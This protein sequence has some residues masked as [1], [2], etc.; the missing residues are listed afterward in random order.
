VLRFTQVTGAGSSVLTTSEQ[1]PIPPLRFQPGDPCRSIDISTTAI[2]TGPVEVTI[3]Y[4]GTT[5][6]DESRLRM[7]HQEG[8]AWVDRTT[9][10]DTAAKK[11]IGTVFSLSPFGIFEPANQPPV[12]ACRNVVNVADDTCRATATAGEINDGS[13]DPDGDPITLAISPSGPFPLGTTPVMLTV[14]D[15]AGETSTCAATVTVVDQSA[16]AV[17]ASFAAI[18]AQKKEG[19]FRVEYTSAD[20]CDASPVNTAVME[21][22]AG[23]GGY[24]VVFERADER[25]ISFR[26]RDRRIQLQGPDEASMRQLLQTILADG[27]AA[28]TPGQELRLHLDESQTMRSEFRFSGNELMEVLSPHLRLRVTARDSSGNSNAATAVPPFASK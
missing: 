5:Y 27:G 11:I 25:K 16:P 9:S 17:T 7:F 24:G 13:S 22:P 14:S 3:D 18:K 23:A 15:A 20:H 2:F 28:V 10:L 21:I 1:C 19:R 4:S 6:R 8:G 12:A 26:S